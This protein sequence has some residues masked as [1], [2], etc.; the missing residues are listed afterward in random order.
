MAMDQKSV[1]LNS[2]GNAWFER[3]KD[4]LGDRDK[5]ADI[6]FQTVLR[7]QSVIR[8]QKRSPISVLEVGCANGFRLSWFR[9]EGFEVCGLDPSQTAI[10]YGRE[11]YGFT[12]NELLSI[13]ARGFFAN[14]DKAFDIIVFAHSFY[15]I[16]RADLPAIVAGAIN[17]LSQNGIV[18]IYDFHAAPH[19]TAY[20]HYDGL[21]SYKMDYASIFTAFPQMKLIEQTV[22][23]HELTPTQ[24]DPTEDC[25][26]SVI[27]LV[28]ERFAYPQINTQG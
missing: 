27:K 26:M 21:W 4:A 10:E 17:S 2:E 22:I 18:A 6:I 16:P 5:T 28:D 13:D 7:H 15:L 12:A 3:N 1:F 8:S 24:G 23:E 11:H 25:A 20:S 9:D 14:N 19:K